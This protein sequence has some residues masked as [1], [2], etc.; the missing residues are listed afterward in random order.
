MEIPFE[1]PPISFEELLEKLTEHEAFLKRT[2]TTDDDS[3][4]SA[5]VANKSNRGGGLKCNWNNS[6]AASS[7]SSSIV[8]DSSNFNKKQWN[9][10][11]RNFNSGFAYKGKCQLCT[12]NWNNSGAANSRSNNIVQDSS[13]FN[14]KQWNTNNKNFNSGSTCKGKCQLCTPTT[15]DDSVISANVANKLNCGGGPKRNWNNYGAA[16]SQSSNTVQDSSNSNKKQWNTNN[17][18]FNSRST[19]KENCQLCTQQGHSARRCTQLCQ[20]WM[21]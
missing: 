19:Y 7:R 5:N 18:N 21:F 10:N 6:G 13:N 15:D 3:I 1:K 14:K 2:P 8:Q 4:I 17:N 9:T 20:Q 11:N 12:P 16:N